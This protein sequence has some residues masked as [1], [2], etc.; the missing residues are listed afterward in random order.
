MEGGVS[1]GISDLVIN[2]I[3][4]VRLMYE[5]AVID[6]LPNI[7]QT[8]VKNLSNSLITDTMNDP[9]YSSCPL[10]IPN[11]SPIDLQKLLRA[12]SNED[13]A[14]EESESYRDIIP[15]I[16]NLIET[17]LLQAPADGGPLPINELLGSL[18]VGLSGRSGT[19]NV[20]S[21]LLNV[22]LE[23]GLDSVFL[24]GVEGIHLQL[25]NLTIDNINTIEDTTYILKPIGG[26][27]ASNVIDNY[28]R[29]GGDLGVF[30][31]V[32]LLIEGD[33]PLAMRNKLK[34]GASLS[35]LNVLLNLELNIPESSVFDFP[36]RDIHEIPCW[37]AIIPP[38]F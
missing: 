33:S 18:T 38:S 26:G 23:E 8:T 11:D 27:E 3:D 7:I 12:P 22:S 1:S 20:S 2:V 32:M 25:S 29:F 5:E 21:T 37:L 34:L 6:V 19:I 30:A 4:A 31:D 28:I 16:L 10:L 36:L 14:T 35:E 13:S 15:S 17:R 24:S 9:E